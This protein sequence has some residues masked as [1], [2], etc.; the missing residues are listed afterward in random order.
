MLELGE[1]IRILDYLSLTN[2]GLHTQEAEIGTETYAIG[3]SNE[4]R[5]IDN[6]VGQEVVQLRIEVGL[7]TKKFITMNS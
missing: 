5:V 2:R 7:L 6:T 1:S 3:A 4:H